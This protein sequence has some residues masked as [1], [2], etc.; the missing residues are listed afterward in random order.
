MA[1]ALNTL[2][3]MGVNGNAFKRLALRLVLRFAGEQVGES[4][5]DGLLTDLDE[6]SRLRIRLREEGAKDE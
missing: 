3:A 6:A 1:N 2:Y 5:L 4:Q